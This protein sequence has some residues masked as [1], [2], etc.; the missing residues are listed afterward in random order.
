MCYDEDN[1][2]DDSPFFDDFDFSKYYEEKCKEHS[3][4][5]RKKINDLIDKML[6]GDEQARET[7]IVSRLNSVIDIAKKYTGRGLDL[8]DLIQEGNLALIQAVDSYNSHV[9]E[10]FAAYTR[11]HIYSHLSRLLENLGQPV[12]IPVHVQEVVSQIKRSRELLSQKLGRTPNM[13]DIA[14]HIGK[15]YDYTLQISSIA[16]DYILEEDA[17]SFENEDI[18]NHAIDTESKSPQEQA[19]IRECR[20]AIYRQFNTLTP[21]EE[22]V[23]VS[24]FGFDDGQPKTLEEVGNYINRT[25]ERI[26][27]I[28]AKALRKLRHP[29]R[30]RPLKSFSTIEDTCD[31]YY[32]MSCVAQ[33]WLLRTERKI[34]YP[35]R[36]HLIESSSREDIQKEK[37]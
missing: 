28:E 30:S 18:I 10:T 11:Q 5:S 3:T 4:Q 35:I 19:L 29:S 23:I 15:S 25:R 17:L 31:F 24:R 33:D 16:G 8:E 1:Y 13:H 36:N 32:S 21:L 6:A 9:R 34:N 2:F 14:N 7:L 27:Q 22:M 37:K 20:R 12:H 26:R